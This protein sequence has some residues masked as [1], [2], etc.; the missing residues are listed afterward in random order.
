[1]CGLLE[2]AGIASERRATQ[3]GSKFGGAYEVLVGAE[4]LEAAQA[5]L[6]SDE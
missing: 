6:Q 5:L 3:S 1:M 2:T 4:D